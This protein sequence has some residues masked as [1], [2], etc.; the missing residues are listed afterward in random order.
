MGINI[1]YPVICI[2]CVCRE[3]LALRRSVFGYKC[4]L[5]STGPCTH[6]TVFDV[7]MSSIV[8]FSVILHHSRISKRSLTESIFFKFHGMQFI[9]IASFVTELII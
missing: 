9:S 4:F 7:S 3:M 6:T 2:I 8:S 5:R 1:L